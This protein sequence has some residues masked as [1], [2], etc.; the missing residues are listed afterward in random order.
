MYPQLVELQQQLEHQLGKRVELSRYIGFGFFCGTNNL[1]NRQP[2]CW[3]RG[4]V[5]ATWS[6]SAG[7]KGV[8]KKIYFSSN[9]LKLTLSDAGNQTATA[10]IVKEEETF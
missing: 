1:F 7:K 8:L 2:A 9:P 10:S 5:P 3:G 6:C 4:T